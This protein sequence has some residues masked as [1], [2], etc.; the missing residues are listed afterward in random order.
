VQI[1]ET[2]AIIA[3]NGSYP[4]A[5]ARGARKAGVKRVVAVAFTDETREDFA[6]EV[7]EITWLRVGQ[8]G[9][10]LA[11][12]ERAGAQAGVMAGQIAPKNLFDLRPDFKTLFLL[13]KLKRRNAETIFRA[14]GEEMQKVGCPLISAT[15]FMGD[16]L[17]GSGLLFGPK[18][19]AR[20]EDDLHYGHEIA[21]E[22]A[23]LD[24]GQTVLVKNG[25]VLAV[26]GFE[27]TNECI[28][29]GGALGRGDAV[30]VKVSKPGQDPR[31]DVPVVGPVTIETCAAAGIRVIGIEA[32]H[33]IVLERERVAELAVQ[34][35]VSIF[36]LAR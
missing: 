7:D 28:K 21:K 13:A 22:V 10:L 31:F 11:F 15:S 4:F 23:R 33:T 6:R 2:L 5:M 25:T 20:V 18:V 19:K 36:G 29:R 12:I 35:K 1:P 34:Q 8:L 3:G 27:G 26:E 14:I 32:G 24:I 9:K 17:A 16:H 30:M